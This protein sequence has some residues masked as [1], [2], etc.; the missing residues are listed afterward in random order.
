MTSYLFVHRELLTHLVTKLLSTKI[1]VNCGSA[2]RHATGLFFCKKSTK[3][4]ANWKSATLFSK[5]FSKTSQLSRLS[6][7]GSNCFQ[8]KFRNPPTSDML[9]RKAYILSNI[10]T[11]L[12]DFRMSD[13]LTLLL[14]FW[15]QPWYAILSSNAIKF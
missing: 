7:N 1:E 13:P 12:Q 3:F 2:V 8:V 4:H 6:C 5:L 10:Y 11:I 15:L 9:L 14:K